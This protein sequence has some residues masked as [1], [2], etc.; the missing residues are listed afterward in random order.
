MLHIGAESRK[1]WLE[2]N[3]DDD[4]EIHCRMSLLE[5]K[6]KIVS[7]VCTLCCNFRMAAVGVQ[8]MGEQERQ[9]V[10]F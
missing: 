6:K 10:W 3:N 1:H 7:L 8:R 4:E 5:V 9:Q 2:R